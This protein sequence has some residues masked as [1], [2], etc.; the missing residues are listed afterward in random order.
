MNGILNIYKE[1]G[2]TSFDVVA[3]LRRILK[4]KKIGHTGTLDP[5]AEGVL[6]VCVGRATRLCEL[7]TDGT[8]T[9]EAVLLLGTETD[10]LD[11]EGQVLRTCPVDC[12]PED[13]QSC[14]ASFLGEQEQIPPMYSALKVNGKRLYDLAREGK[15]V[16][17]KARRVVFYELTVLQTELPRIRIRVNCSK[18]TYI[19]SLCDDIG[20]KL[21][22]GGCMEKLVR[23]QSGGFVI[24]EA[25]KLSEIE[26]LA[27]EGRI[28][29]VLIPMDAVFAG[30]PAVYTLPEGDKAAHN[31]NAVPAERCVFEPAG[32]GEEDGETPADGQQVRLYDAQKHFIGIYAF[33]TE[34]RI[35]KPLKV[36]WSNEI[37]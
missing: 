33:Q 18:G 11:M 12:T 16:E 31:G 22:C 19:R 1:P 35:Y 34:N 9:Y 30:I 7:L 25:K 5:A 4:E 2:W 6:P 27:A 13:V 32:C 36:L 15:S 26:A 29:E 14:I 3:K 37:L 17:R 20:R 28:R 21:G 24:E 10:T 23:T 8:K